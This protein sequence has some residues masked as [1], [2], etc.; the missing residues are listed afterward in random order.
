MTM[1]TTTI[2]RT[3]AESR[4]RLI[5]DF[6]SRIGVVVANYMS[7]SRAEQQLAELDDRLLLDI[8]VSR[9]DIHAMVWGKGRVRD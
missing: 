3:G 5:P 2:N 4:S 8:G 1:M 7:R 6:L 9:S